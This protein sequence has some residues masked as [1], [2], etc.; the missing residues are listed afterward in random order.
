LSYFGDTGKEGSVSGE[1]YESELDDESEPGNLMEKK[2]SR[3][4]QVKMKCSLKQFVALQL[5]PFPSASFTPFSSHNSQ[6]AFTDIVKD[7][8]AMHLDVLLIL[9]EPSPLV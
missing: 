6:S 7:C 2:H 1:Y 8:L 3:K 4:G 5:E 9:C